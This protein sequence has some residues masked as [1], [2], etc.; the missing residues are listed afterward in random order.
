MSRGGLKALAQA[1]DSALAG[2]LGDAYSRSMYRHGR[3]QRFLV[4]PGSAQRPLLAAAVRSA[5]LG[6]SLLVCASGCGTSTRETS[7]AADAI[8]KPELLCAR[9]GADRVE[10]S[11]FRGDG[12]NDISK[13]FVRSQEVGGVVLSCKELDLNADGRKD[14]LVYFDSHGRKLREEFDHDFDGLADMKSYYEGGQLVRQELDVDFDGKPDLVEHFENGK[15]VRLEKFLA[16]PPVVPAPAAAPAATAPAA[17]KL[18]ADPTAPAG[19]LPSLSSTPVAPS[20]YPAAPDSA[21]PAPTPGS[22]GSR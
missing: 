9:A 5:V 22:S 18:P 19:P 15:R 7:G 12:K 13:V 11:S 17:A 14:M 3:A 8:K 16:P 2:P 4:S 6:A 1:G 10:V 20:A 21:S